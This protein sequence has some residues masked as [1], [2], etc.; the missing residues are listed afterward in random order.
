MS[1][2]TFN[3]LFYLR[4]DRV[5]QENLYPIY[6]RITVNNN[7]TFININ[8][9]I[10]EKNWNQTKQCV[11]KQID[12]EINDCINIY[13]N[14]IHE[15]YKQLIEERKTVTALSIKAILL[16]NEEETK[17]FLKVA[18]YH[19]K[20]FEDNIGTRYSYGSYKNY[21]TTLKYLREF[22]PKF[23]RTKDLQLNQLNYKFLTDFEHFLKTKE[24]KK[25][26]KCNHNGAMKHIQRL[27]RIVNMAIANDW[28]VQN[29][30]CKYKVSYNRY[31]R[32]Y[33]NWQELNILMQAPVKNIH[34]EV[35]K[36]L[37][38]FA[39]FTGLSYVDVKNLKV[40]DVSIGIDSQ[41]WLFILRAKT[42]TKSIIPL[43]PVPIEIL[44]KYKY[45]FRDKNE[46]MF[47]V[48]SNQKINDHLKAI[49]K[50]S[51][52]NKNLSFHMGRHTAATTVL[53]SNGVPI[54]TVSKILGHTN[55]KTTQIYARVLENKV[56]TDIALLR[57]KLQ[58][59]TVS[60]LKE[61]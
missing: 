39:C 6:L 13:R 24:I 54:E 55:I 40:S 58:E 11:K 44:D 9:S 4:K 3:Y 59:R 61:A 21:K 34:Q 17:T 5:N 15:I 47:P 52:I 31:D 32:E 1:K 33:L 7:R 2:S 46:L 27:K 20:N 41:K 16:G 8:R 48:T 56:A 35:A 45:S 30:F 19:N 57:N 12:E 60:N 43:L 23:Y 29:P 37:F 10:D 22:I 53:L 26:R 51:N 14:R 36:D 25:K 38:V 50:L 18:E 28:I 42:D 49:A